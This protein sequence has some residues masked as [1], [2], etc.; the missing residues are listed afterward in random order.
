LTQGPLYWQFLF[1]QN[2]P[3]SLSPQGW[4]DRQIKGRRRHFPQGSF[5]GFNTS[6]LVYTVLSSHRESSSSSSSSSLS[7]LLGG[8]K[9][10]RHILVDCT[11]QLTRYPLSFPLHW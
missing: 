6:G 11:V 5:R 3:L 9:W 4:S 1:R 10:G 7:L 2:I 8:V